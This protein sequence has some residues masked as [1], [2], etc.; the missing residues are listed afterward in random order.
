MGQESKVLAC[1]GLQLECIKSTILLMTI[2]IIIKH[3]AS[4]IGGG[5]GVEFQVVVAAVVPPEDYNLAA[6]ALNS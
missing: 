4:S 1:E 6:S 3:L 5:E 2:I